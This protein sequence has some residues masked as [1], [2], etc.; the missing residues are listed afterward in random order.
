MILAAIVALSALVIT[1]IAAIFAS[2]PVI[3]SG[4]APYVV[5]LCSYVGQGVR[6]FNS[7]THAEIVLPLLGMLIGV[8]VIYRG[9]KFAMWVY[10]KVP[11]IGVH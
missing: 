1:A 6:I 10:A 9:Y 4:Y 2:M 3:P 8:Q 5:Q 11:M 7:F